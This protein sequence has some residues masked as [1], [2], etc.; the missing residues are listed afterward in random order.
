[1]DGSNVIFIVLPIVIPRV[2]PVTARTAD[3]ERRLVP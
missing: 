1:M 3:P 2:G